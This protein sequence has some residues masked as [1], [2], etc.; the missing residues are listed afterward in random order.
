MSE[1]RLGHRGW[2][3]RGAGLAALAY[4]LLLPPFAHAQQA[5]NAAAAAEAAREP[6]AEVEREDAEPNQQDELQGVA[7]ATHLPGFR[8]GMRL[9][10]KARSYYLNRNRDTKQDNAGWALGGALEFKSGWLNERLQLAA[11]VYTSQVLYG[12]EDKDGT[13]LFLPGPEEFT[14]LGEAYATIRLG[15]KEGLRVGRQSFDLPWLARHDI[16]MAPNTF[17]AVAI[18]RQAD[19]GFSYIAGYVDGIKRKNDDTFISM[20][21]AAGAAGSDEGLGLLGAQYTLADGSLVG[22]T[23]Q[24]AFDVMNT[25]FIK[26]EKSF[27]LANGMSVRAFAQYTDQRSIGDE[28]IGPFSTYLAAVKGELSFPNGSF[29]LAA[30]RAGS[31]KGLQSPF[32][33]PP[34]YLSI[35][36]DNFDRAGEESYLVG[37]SYDLSDLGVPGLSFMTN[38]A[39]GRTPDTGPNASPDETEYDLTVDYRVPKDRKL[40][41]LWVR[42]RGA[43]IDQDERVAGG[44]DF[45]DF[46]VI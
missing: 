38:I 26:G 21:E 17:E 16:R 46:R 45:F 4:G 10:F 29:R 33:G 18:G 11:V 14:V 3:L 1:H 7:V 12:P 13:Q 34:N 8:E 39:D 19:R 44:D 23:S 32:G 22:A 35:I 20:S 6:G 42:V 31:E 25:F 2:I 9:V 40:S 43:W 28:L 37:L 41:G 15:E 27:P 5:E 30:S 24:T 36:V